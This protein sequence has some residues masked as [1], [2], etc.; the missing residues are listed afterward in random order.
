MTAFDE[1]NSTPPILAPTLVDDTQRRSLPRRL[2]VASAEA[3]VMQLSRRQE[4]IIELVAEGYSGKEVAR[5]LGMSPKT[6]ETHIQ[7][8]F[9][10][11]G[12]RNRA[13][14]VARWMASK[15]PA[16]S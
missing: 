15:H 4:Q 14:V 6:V 12:V 8:I 5:A 10:R 13:G 16:A 3:T 11:Y 9:D 2:T 1:S 7:R